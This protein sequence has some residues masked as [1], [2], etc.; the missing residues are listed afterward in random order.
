MTRPRPHGLSRRG[1]LAGGGALVLSFSLLQP[2][3]LLAQEAQGA[4]PPPQEPKLPG[5]LKTEPML[6]AWIRIDADGTVTVFTG[7]AE[8]GQG[9]KTALIQ[10]AAEQLDV[11]PG[12]VRLI[13]ADTGQTPN[14]GYTAGSHSMQDS[15]TAI[16]HAAAQVRAILIGLAA[17]R[18]DLS[19]RPAAGARWCGRGRGRPPARRMANSS[20]TMSCMCGRS[21]L[22]R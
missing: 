8:L 13:T 19:A 21:R 11:D 12:A 6:D 22:R 14:E 15:G 4:K 9:I 10:V 3:D 2:A 1:V 16:L 5:S 17:T 20:P 18:L 7:K